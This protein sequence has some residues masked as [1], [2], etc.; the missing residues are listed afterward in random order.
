MQDVGGVTKAEALFKIVQGFRIGAQLTY[1]E[2]DPAGSDREYRPSPHDLGRIE[3]IIGRKIVE[4]ELQFMTGAGPYNQ[5]H[6]YLG[7]QL[8][9]EVKAALEALCAT[10]A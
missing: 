10:A 9:E 1:C 6:Y 7:E 2:Y 8:R 4:S 5:D 3:A